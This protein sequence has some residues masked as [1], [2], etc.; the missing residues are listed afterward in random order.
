M[1]PT[2]PSWDPHL[3]ISGSQLILGSR[4]QPP[5]SPAPPANIA[6]FFRP[7]CSST[8]SA[9]KWSGSPFQI[10]FRFILLS[11]RTFVLFWHVFILMSSFFTSLFS[12]LT[13]VHI[14]TS[15]ILCST[16][17]LFLSLSSFASCCSGH[18]QH[19]YC[20]SCYSMGPRGLSPRGGPWHPYPWP[21]YS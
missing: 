15:L 4:E 8:D 20:Y 3:S 14:Y 17:W 9:E 11:L 10:E 16:S 21:C 12:L 2:W 13:V 5:P 19:Q 1:I 6:P 18:S 7:P